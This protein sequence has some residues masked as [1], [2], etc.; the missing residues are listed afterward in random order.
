MHVQYDHKRE[1]KIEA[2]TPSG[3]NISVRN[4]S[5]TDGNHIRT[6]ELCDYYSA[7]MAAPA[8]TEK[9][10]AANPP[11]L[12]FIFRA[13]TAEL[14]EVLLVVLAPAEVALEVPPEVP[15]DERVVIVDP[16]AVLVETERVVVTAPVERDV[17]VT[18]VVAELAPEAVELTVLAWEAD[19]LAPMLNGAEVAKTSSM[20]PILT[21]FNV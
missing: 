10:T 7:M 11:T 5:Y 9:R 4:P 2:D 3:K 15:E 6:H 12:V 20:F 16:I 21:A 8:I 19:G 17:V 13:D 14:G 18:A 1:E